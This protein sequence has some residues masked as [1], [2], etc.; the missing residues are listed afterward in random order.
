M[1]GTGARIRVGLTGLG[2]ELPVVSAAAQRQPKDPERR[3]VG[4]LS[5]G[6]GSV[7]RIVAL[8]AGAHDELADPP[9]VI[10]RPGGRLRG[11]PLIV[12]VVPAHND[13]GAVLV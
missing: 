13:L 10:S 11:V 4:R 8:S 7:H 6:A 1:A 5:I 9:C 12:V 2:D 3:G